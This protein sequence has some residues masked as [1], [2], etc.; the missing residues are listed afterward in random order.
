MET[1]MSGA[2]MS[3]LV[4]ELVLTAIAVAMFLWRSALDMKEEDHLVLDEAESHLV[5]DQAAIRSRV[6]QLSRYIKVVSIA[7]AV[8]AVILFGVWV[9]NGLNLI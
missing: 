7:W 9:E 8:L 4:V 5:R 3:L 6:T 1:Q 2:F